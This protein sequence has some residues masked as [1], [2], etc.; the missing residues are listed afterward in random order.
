[1]VILTAVCVVGGSCFGNSLI[2]PNN[3]ACQVILSAKVEWLLLNMALCSCYAGI[4]MAK[5]KSTILF[6]DNYSQCW[7]Y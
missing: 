2:E 6:D 5:P 7:T 4:I 1:M 3:S